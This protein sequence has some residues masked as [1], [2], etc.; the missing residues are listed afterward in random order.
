MK[1]KNAVEKGKSSCHPN[2]LKKL[3]LFWGVIFYYNRKKRK[4]KTRIFFRKRS[5]P[6]KKQVVC[7]S[8]QTEKRDDDEKNS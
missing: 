7:A 5:I 3:N 1:N 4:G 6:V 2:N 8:L